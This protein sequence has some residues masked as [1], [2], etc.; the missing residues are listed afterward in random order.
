[1]ADVV[2]KFSEA[3]DLTGVIKKWRIKIYYMDHMGDI[4]VH[5]ASDRTQEEVRVALDR[6]K[7][8]F[9]F[10]A[11]PNALG[12]GYTLRRVVEMIVEPMTL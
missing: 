8:S 1:M 4:R 2:P 12:T 3:T 5:D 10:I 9:G 11:R 6:L 7:D